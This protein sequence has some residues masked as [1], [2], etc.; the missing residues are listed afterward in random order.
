MSAV[1]GWTQADERDQREQYFKA[2]H[3]WAVENRVRYAG[4]SLTKIPVIARQGR[5]MHSGAY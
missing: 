4:Q 3:R 2:Q 5:R 1:D